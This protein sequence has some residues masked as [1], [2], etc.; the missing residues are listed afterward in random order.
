MICRGKQETGKGHRGVIPLR[1][2]RHGGEWKSTELEYP[3][4]F[5]CNHLLEASEEGL[6]DTVLETWLR[7]SV[8]T[9]YPLYH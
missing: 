1:K 4:L 8:R 7:S 5:L 3:G 2:E 9:I 6:S